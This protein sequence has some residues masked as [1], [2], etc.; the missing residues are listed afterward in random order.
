[1]RWR[2]LRRCAT[3]LRERVGS[4][5]EPCGVVPRRVRRV[6]KSAR[7]PG[8]GIH[9]GTP[10]PTSSL[11]N[12][13]RILACIAATE[14]GQ[15]DTTSLIRSDRVVEVLVEVRVR[16][17]LPAPYAAAARSLLRHDQDAALLHDT[18]GYTPHILLTRT[19]LPRVGKSVCPARR[20]DNPVARGIPVG[21]L[22]RQ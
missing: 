21:G 11:P 8:L 17:A 9:A 10:P 22:E 7:C 14:I 13:N 5:A 20:L 16:P 18:Q 2:C 12:I 1:M 3:S 6:E 15:G 19:S 4:H